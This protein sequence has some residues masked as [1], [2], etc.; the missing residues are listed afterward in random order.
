MTLSK[1]WRPLSLPLLM[2]ALRATHSLVQ[3]HIIGVRICLCI[4]TL[5]DHSSMGAEPSLSVLSSRLCIYVNTLSHMGSFPKSHSRICTLSKTLNTICMHTHTRTTSAT[6]S[7]QLKQILSLCP[8]SSN[9]ATGWGHDSCQVDGVSWFITAIAFILPNQ[10]GP[11]TLMNLWLFI[12][13]GQA[14]LCVTSLVFGS[15]AWRWWI[16]WSLTYLP[17]T[18]F[19]FPFLN[20]IWPHRGLFSPNLWS[21]SFPN[22]INALIQQAIKVW[23]FVSASRDHVEAL[24][25]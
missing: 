7:Y 11:H 9:T 17:P 12:T 21:R 15:V 5:C 25:F 23:P 19:F 4:H 16:F 14:F 22:T 8:P 1:R 2:A 6:P 10:P 3:N 13:W 20:S 18:E 24:L